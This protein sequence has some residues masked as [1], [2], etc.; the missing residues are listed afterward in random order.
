MP[1][2]VPKED[3]P[4][5]IIRHKRLIILVLLITGFLFGGN[6]YLTRSTE[7]SPRSTAS[8]LDSLEDSTVDENGP[9]ATVNGV[10]ISRADYQKTLKKLTGQL[11][12]DGYDLSNT[13]IV[14]Q[15]RQQAIATLVNTELI[16]QDAR[17]HGRSVSS[18][19]LTAAYGD[20]LEEMGSEEVLF[21]TLQDAGSNEKELR[22]ELERELLVKKHLEAMTDYKS[23]TVSEEEIRAYFDV[24]IINNTDL[25][26]YEAEKPEL[27]AKLLADKRQQA[28][29]DF[30]QTLRSEAEVEI[31]I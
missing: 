27:R 20:V 4:N 5:F 11:S 23:I 24:L 14:A 30:I 2:P 1:A 31:H 6:Y 25:A 21:L 8:V 7:K 19:E 9:I 13:K 3:Q 10:A 28:V 18:A 22:A 17:E 16:V 15:V 26:S 29:S 12:R